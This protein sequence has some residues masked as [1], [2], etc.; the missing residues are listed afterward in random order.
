MCAR[1]EKFIP[2]CTRRGKKRPLAIIA[3]T[4]V[5]TLIYTAWRSVLSRSPTPRRRYSIKHNII[6][7]RCCSNRSM[8]VPPR[9]HS[10][11]HGRYMYDNI[12]L[13]VVRLVCTR[14]RFM[15]STDST[16]CTTRPQCDYNIRFDDF[17]GYI[18][19]LKNVKSRTG[20]RN[21]CMYFTYNRRGKT[22]AVLHCPRN[23]TG[24]LYDFCIHCR[25]YT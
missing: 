22:I 21:F 6:L 15:C 17:A 14:T 3:P 1:R 18:D 12:T 8:P 13:N 24:F 4:R 5:F 11:V 10:F 25:L 2:S 9:P 20:Y 7:Y 19:H 16:S 23:T